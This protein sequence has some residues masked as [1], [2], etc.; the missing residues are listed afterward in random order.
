MYCRRLTGLGGCGGGVVVGG[1][2][3]SGGVRS[4]SSD[5]SG[6]W[7][8]GSSLPGILLSV[9][10]SARKVAPTDRYRTLAEQSSVA[11]LLQHELFIVIVLPNKILGKVVYQ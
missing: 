10:S 1:A 2:A 8:W 9:Q 4:S 6:G 3:V 7:C 11:L 5:E